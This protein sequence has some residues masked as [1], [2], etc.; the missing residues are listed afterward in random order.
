MASEYGSDAPLSVAMHRRPGG[1]RLEAPPVFAGNG[2]SSREGMIA[3]VWTRVLTG[4]VAPRVQS[5]PGSRP[6]RSFPRGKSPRS[7]RRPAGLLVGHP[8]GAGASQ[9]I[10]ARLTRIHWPLSTP[11]LKM[12]TLRFSESHSEVFEADGV[13]LTTPILRQSTTGLLP[14]LIYYILY[15]N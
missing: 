2:G 5:A 6:A 4:P 1:A 13:D 10:A 11:R 7:P 8:P 3:R 15:I 9:P 14:T 12:T